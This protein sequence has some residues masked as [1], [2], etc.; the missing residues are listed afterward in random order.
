LKTKTENFFTI[1]K[2]LSP[3]L[4]GANL[5]RNYASDEKKKPNIIKNING[6]INNLSF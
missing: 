1:D 5:R 6:R 3:K 4:K 2:N